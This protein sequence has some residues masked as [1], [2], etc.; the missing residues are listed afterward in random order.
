MPVFEEKFEWMIGRYDELMVASAQPD[1]IADLPRWQNILREIA[2]LEPAVTAWRDYVSLRQEIAS[3]E[4]LLE[5]PDYTA[6][7]EE[8]LALL[9]PRQEAALQ[10]LKVFLLPRDP[11]DDKNVVME[12]RAGAG[13]DEAGLFGAMLMR[14]YVRYAERHGYTT[15]NMSISES[16][17]GGVKEAVF[18]ISGNGAFSRLKYESGVHRVQRVPVTESSGR[19]HTSTATVAVLP[20]ADEVDVE[21]NQEDLRIDSLPCQR[22]WRTVHQYDGLGHPHHAPAQRPGGDLPGRKEPAEKQGA[23]DARAARAPVRK[24]A[25]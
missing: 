6:I 4:E 20:E 10:E 11:N 16:E 19:I 5:Q 17:L 15:T 9:R 24:D 21:I 22:A 8:E 2:Q 1:I 13:G 18:M 12:I 3:A 14:M 25:G 23:G 7:A